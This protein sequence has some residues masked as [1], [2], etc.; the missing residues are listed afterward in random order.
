MHFQQWEGTP[1]GRGDHQVPEWTKL[2]LA[3]AMAE[4][5]LAVECLDVLDEQGKPT[6]E[7]R[8]R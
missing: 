5:P 8:P 3:E 7:V 1:I 6:G 4:P 2:L